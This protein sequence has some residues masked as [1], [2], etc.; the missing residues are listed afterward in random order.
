M[1]PG[2]RGSLPVCVPE[3]KRAICFLERA[4]GIAPGPTP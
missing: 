1:H 4:L 3:T 2:K